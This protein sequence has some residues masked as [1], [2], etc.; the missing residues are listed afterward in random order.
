MLASPGAISTSRMAMYLTTDQNAGNVEECFY[1][2][3][4]LQSAG[5]GAHC[6]VKIAQ[7]LVINGNESASFITRIINPATAIDN[8]EVGGC[9]VTD[10]EFDFVQ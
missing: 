6:G 5:G 2:P 7:P 8:S 1:M 9:N 3:T 4:Y 10:I